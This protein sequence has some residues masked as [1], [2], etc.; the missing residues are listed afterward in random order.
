[1]YEVNMIYMFKNNLTGI[2]DSLN[3]DGIVDK[4]INLLVKQLRDK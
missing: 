1:M 4:D 3:I 2:L